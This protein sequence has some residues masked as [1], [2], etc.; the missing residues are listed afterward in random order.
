VPPATVCDAPPPLTPADKTVAL[1]TPPEDTLSLAP[2]TIIMPLA[3][4]PLE[5][6][7]LPPLPIVALTARPPDMTFNFA[8]IISVPP[9]AT[10]A[11]ES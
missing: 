9:L 10:T 6:V 3:A 5:M 2:L 1:A 11:P 8:S 7:S 4:P